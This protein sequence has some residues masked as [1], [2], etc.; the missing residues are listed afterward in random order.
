[1]EY[2]NLSNDKYKDL[3]STAI[4]IPLLGF[5]FLEVIF[6]L[7]SNFIIG[8]FQIPSYLLYLIPVFSFFQAIPTFLPIIFQS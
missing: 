1:M 4:L 7:F 5:I 6:F 8:Y 3:V 2:S